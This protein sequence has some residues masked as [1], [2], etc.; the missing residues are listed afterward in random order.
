MTR[1]K[2]T[3]NESDAE[4]E[5]TTTPTKSVRV[6]RSRKPTQST[7][8]ADDELSNP[9][10]NTDEDEVGDGGG[11]SLLR[12]R[13]PSLVTAIPSSDDLAGYSD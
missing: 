9:E 3:V 1:K 7:L 4:S 11:T 12:V 5:G 2:P 10:G 13:K 6:L 8:S